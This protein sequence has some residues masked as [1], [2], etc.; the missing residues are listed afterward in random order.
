MAEK[1]KTIL[2]IEDEPHI[3]MGL[4]D[5]LEFE[6]VRF[7]AP[8]GFSEVSLDERQQGDLR[9]RL[10][11]PLYYDPSTATHRRWEAAGLGDT[12]DEL[13]VTRAKGQSR[14][15][16]DPAWELHLCRV[17]A[18]DHDPTL[19]P[20]QCG[21]R[22]TSR[23]V[24]GIDMR[25]IVRREQ[26]VMTE[27]QFLLLRRDDIVM[28]SLELYG[29][30]RFEGDAFWE[31]LLASLENDRPL[32]PPT[33]SKVWP[34]MRSILL[35]LVPGILLGGAWVWWRQRRKPRFVPRAKLPPATP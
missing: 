9:E 26:G 34:L 2:V 27:Y 7:Q 17:F 12:T 18:Q 13:L 20:L 3:V 33:P 15:A 23:G 6:G 31:P 1:R 22:T 28:I 11:E 5:A 21:R 4:R 29:N 30:R 8:A 24:V 14:P 16:E 25:R 35:V 10:I 32:P 19:G